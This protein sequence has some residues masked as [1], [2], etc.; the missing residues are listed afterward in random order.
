MP[1]QRES[2]NIKVYRSYPQPYEAQRV[3]ETGPLLLQDFHLARNP[4]LIV[5]SSWTNI[6]YFLD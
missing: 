6:L 2:Q 3:A 1:L 4:T 5:S